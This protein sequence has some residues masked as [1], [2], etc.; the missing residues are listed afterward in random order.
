MGILFGTNGCRRMRET[1][2]TTACAVSAIVSQST[3]WAS[4]EPGPLPTSRNPWA[5]SS[6]VSRLRA[7]RSR[8][9]ASVKNSIPQLV[10]WMTNH[11]RVP[12][13]LYEITSE[14]MA[15]SLA[16]PPALRMT[17]A[18][19]WLS[20]AY[21][22]G[23]SLASMHVRMAKRRAGGSAR[24]PSWPNEAAYVALAER[25]SL[26]TF[27]I[28]SPQCV[29]EKKKAPDECPG[30]SRKQSSIARSRQHRPHR[31][32]EQAHGLKDETRAGDMCR[33]SII[34]RG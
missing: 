22:E 24:L 27:G 26:S 6:A 11:S 15:S 3:N 2:S 5:L 8:M 18:S 7:R 32:R 14:R 23:S 19:P 16:R 34:D 25:T 10:W 1:S 20:P 31:G 29:V 9:R 33:E 13:S 30:H 17:C 28:G 12:R 21:L 4:V